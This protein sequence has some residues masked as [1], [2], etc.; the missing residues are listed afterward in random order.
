MQ[1]LVLYCSSMLLGWTAVLTFINCC[2]FIANAKILQCNDSSE[3]PYFS[4]LARLLVIQTGRDSDYAFILGGTK[5]MLWGCHGMRF[6]C[7]PILLAP[8]CLYCQPPCRC[9]FDELSKYIFASIYYLHRQEQHL[10]NID[11][12]KG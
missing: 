2:L 7:F 1:E 11:E 3:M 8:W 4:D 10:T 12:V 9:L 6:F 5:R